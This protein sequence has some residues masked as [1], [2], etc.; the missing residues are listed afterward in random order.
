MSVERIYKRTPGILKV[1]STR[2]QA[3]KGAASL[4]FAV[5]MIRTS[6]AAAQDAVTVT[7][8]AA[9]DTTGFTPQQVEAF[10][11]ENPN[12]QINYQEQGAITT[13]LHDKFVTVA[14]AQDSTADVVSMDVPFV[15]EFAAA[16]WTLPMDDFLT[17]EERSEFFSGTIDGATY[18]GVLY[19]IPWYNNGPGLFYRK[20]VLDEAGIKPPATYDDLVSASQE[21]AT[22]DVSG[23][24]FQAAQT[25]GGVINFLEYLWGHGD[26]LLDENMEVI[27]GDS[28]AGTEALTRLVNYIYEDQISPE[29]CLTMRLAADAENV[30]ASGEAVFLRSWMTATSAMQSEASQV[31]DAW[32]VTT[33]P[34]KDGSEPGPGCLGTWNLGISAFSEHL[35]EA[36]EVIRFFT[37]LEQQTLRYLGNGNLPARSAVF[38][39]PEVT[40]KYAYVDRLKPAFE[41]LKPRPVTPYY[42]QMSADVLQP[43][44][45]AAM[46]RQKT[47][48]EAVADMAEGL[49]QVLGG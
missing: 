4:T 18:D 12:I 42:S 47:P 20:D 2:R 48:E 11:A 30:F 24:V 14:T 21:L 7:W 3:L 6:R 36:A 27:L 22:P 25:E 44:Y 26:E 35:E 49:R 31:Q 40:E 15:P 10:N 16:G 38:E 37:S 9:R 32:D 28:E 34:S 5:P 13:D 19:A 8:F 39:D 17:E 43:N 23:F 1:R 46:S 29:S 33:L 45:G 41:A